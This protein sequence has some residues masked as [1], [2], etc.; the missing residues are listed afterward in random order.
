MHKSIPK[1]QN[2]TFRY[3]KKENE[4]LDKNL[5]HC[6]PRNMWFREEVNKSWKI[7]IADRNFVLR[8]VARTNVLKKDLDQWL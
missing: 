4:I 1:V 5:K 3:V 2:L 7:A 8:S 6:E